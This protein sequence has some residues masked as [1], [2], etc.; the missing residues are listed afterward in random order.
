MA[1][2]C[3]DGLCIAELGRGEEKRVSNWVVV[4]PVA[5]GSLGLYLCLRDSPDNTVSALAND[6]LNVVLLAYIEG[7]LAGAGRI[8]GL[9]SRHLD[10]S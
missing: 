5:R 2:F 9:S 4:P 8:G 3:P 1:T 7:D 10:K 6:I